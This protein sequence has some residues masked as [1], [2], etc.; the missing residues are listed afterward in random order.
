D[1]NQAETCRRLARFG[2]RSDVWRCSGA[3]GVLNFPPECLDFVYLDARLDCQSVRE[4]LESWWPLVRRQGVI[5]GHD[6]RDGSLPNGVYGVKSAVDA[7]F[8]LLGLPVHATIDDVP[9]PSWI[10]VKPAAGATS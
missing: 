9:W 5:A 2:A 3:D 10:V 7:F 1:G 6:Y 4:D 8:D